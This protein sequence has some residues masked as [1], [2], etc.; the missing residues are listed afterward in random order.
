MAEEEAEP[1]FSAEMNTDSTKPMFTSI[2]THYWVDG[3]KSSVQK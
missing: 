2:V 3:L 1:V